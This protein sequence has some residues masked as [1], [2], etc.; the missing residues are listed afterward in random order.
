[1]HIRPARTPDAPVIAAL[2]APEVSAGRL[3]PR[4]VDPADFLV[5]EDELGIAGFV[6]LKA[7]TDAV[8]ELGSLVAV[9][10]GRGVGRRLVDAAM[11]AASQRGY[12]AV[13]ALTGEPAFFERV[14]FAAVHATPWA[15]A[16]GCET[17]P[18]HGDLDL[19]LG[20]KSET[21]GQCD[22]L[23]T[24]SQALLARPARAAAR[25]CA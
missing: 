4:A 3:L 22:R 12:S 13:V 21:C 23:S 11:D 7:L 24:C 15:R 16:R 14:G 6:A 5:A 10:R 20:V 1:M 19:A 9:R 2:M 25:V 17:L 8:T 18:V